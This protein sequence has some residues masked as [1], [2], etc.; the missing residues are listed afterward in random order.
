M[1]VI[2]CIL[3]YKINFNLNQKR[4][5]LSLLLASQDIKNLSVTTHMHKKYVKN[6]DI[7]WRVTCMCL[8]YKKLRLAP[9]AKSCKNW[10]N[11][12]ESYHTQIAFN[13]SDAFCD[14][15]EPLWITTLLP[16][17]Y[18]EIIASSKEVINNSR[19]VVLKNIL[20]KP[21]N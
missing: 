13:Q 14:Y 7:S 5:T 9:T 10:M 4:H 20:E 11:E 17:P 1:K 18:S 16:G 15:Y 12:R 3:T 8:C 21:E 2:L 6:D 19:I